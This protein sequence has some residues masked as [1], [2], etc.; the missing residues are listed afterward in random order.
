M[1]AVLAFVVMK[2]C[3][4]I[5]SEVAGGLNAYAEKRELARLFCGRTSPDCRRAFMEPPRTAIILPA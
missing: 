2:L 4:A 5:E 3:S 1:R